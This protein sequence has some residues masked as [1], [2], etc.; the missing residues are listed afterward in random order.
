MHTSTMLASPDTITLLLDAH[1]ASPVPDICYI[2]HQACTALVL[3]TVLR[4]RSR[5]HRVLF[6]SR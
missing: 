4:L 5:C 6:L 2:V 3:W 1:H